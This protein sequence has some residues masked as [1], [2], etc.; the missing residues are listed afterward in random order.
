MA[1]PA[2]TATPPSRSTEHVL[3]VDPR[4]PAPDPQTL[5]LLLVQLD[6]L[7]L[8]DGLTAYGSADDPLLPVGEL[9]RLL[10]LE[11][12]V[13]PTDGR[14]TGSLG[15]ARRALL[16]DVQTNTARIGPVAVPLKPGDIAV[17]PAEI[18]VRASVLAQLLPLKFEVDASSLQMKLAATEVLPIQS[19][20]QRV[21][22][23]RDGGPKASAPVMPRSIRPTSSSRRPLSTSR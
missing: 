20:L 1:A 7:T 21:A 13:S 8:T 15:E 19:R 10:E 23:L 9:S 14:V 6:N 4:F 17:D 11:V 16:I 22:R 18:Y 12:E 5:L 3:A 2:P